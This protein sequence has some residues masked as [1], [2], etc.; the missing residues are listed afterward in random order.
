MARGDLGL[1]ELGTAPL[2]FSSTCEEQTKMK[3][4]RSQNLIDEVG[5]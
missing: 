3:V 4:L 5:L 2:A 1:Y